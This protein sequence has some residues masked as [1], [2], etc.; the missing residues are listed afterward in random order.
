MMSPCTLIGCSHFLLPSIFSLSILTTSFFPSLSLLSLLCSC[1]EHNDE[2]ADDDVTPWP[3]NQCVAREWRGC[4]HSQCLELIDAE[5]TEE[6]EGAEQ[7][8]EVGGGGGGLVQEE[9]Q[10]LNTRPEQ[11]GTGPPTC[12]VMDKYRPKRPTT[13]ALFPQQPQAG[14]QVRT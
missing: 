10:P 8:I 4:V 5:E 3:T 6:E 12:S 11:G 14:T 2:D 1:Q 7:K 9:E 13:L